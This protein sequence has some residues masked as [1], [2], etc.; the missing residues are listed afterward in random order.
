MSAMP[1]D[2]DEQDDIDARY[3]RLAQADTSR[4]DASVQRA[5]FAHAARLAAER[6][7]KPGSDA[8]GTR[9]TSRVWR[10][11]LFGGLAAA[12]LVA[13]LVTPRLLGPDSTGTSPHEIASPAPPRAESYVAADKSAQLT[14]EAG[15]D[16]L[17][18]ASS[19]AST[20]AADRRASAPAGGSSARDSSAALRRAAES[21]DIQGASAL[22]DEKPNLDSRDSAG[23]TALMLAVIN[24]RT[25]L[26]NALLDRGAD[27]NVTDSYGETAL[28]AATAGNHTEIAAAL[29][30]AG[31]H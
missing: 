7:A 5:A 29:R 16:A 18:T 9:R 21:G 3:R 11:P 15:S 26:V 8:R 22:L 27:P 1:P 4:P 10:T 24:G 31:A 14:R 28:H 13:L 6:T 2:N 12:A 30:R 23:R 25:D 17:D 20:L 19:N